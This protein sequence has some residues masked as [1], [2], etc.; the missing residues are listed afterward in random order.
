MADDS[1]ASNDDEP[2][3]QSKDPLQQTNHN[4]LEALETPQQTGGSSQNTENNPPQTDTTPQVAEEPLRKTI[5][6]ADQA[7]FTAQQTDASLKGFSDSRDDDNSDKCTAAQERTVSQ[8]NIEESVFTQQNYDS[9]F[10][11]ALDDD[12]CLPGELSCCTRN[13]FLNWPVYCV[14]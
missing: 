8:R 11:L 14:L 7:A 3:D 2:V 12:S 5:D 13:E 6:S 1:E 9:C 10:K 4:P